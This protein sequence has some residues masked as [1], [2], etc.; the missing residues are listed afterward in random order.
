M[1]AGAY[2]IIGDAGETKGPYSLGQ[3]RHMWRDGRVSSHTL[4]C[5]EGY[6]EWLPLSALS[7]LEDQPPSAAPPAM[8]T[9]AYGTLLRGK[10]KES[11]PARFAALVALAVLLLIVVAILFGHA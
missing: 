6:S 11:G 7:E 1:S 4:Y 3:L 10:P 2:Y 5:E 9:S 8:P